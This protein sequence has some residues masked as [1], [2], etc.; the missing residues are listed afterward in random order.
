MPQYQITSPDGSSYEITAPDGASQD[1]VLNYAKQNIQPPKETKQSI[2]DKVLQ[3]L[4]QAAAGTYDTGDTPKAVLGG[5][6]AGLS[7]IGNVESELYAK[8]K[9]YLNG[10]NEAT[11]AYQNSPDFAKTQQIN[12]EQQGLV[13]KINKDTGGTR[14][15]PL[16][17]D[18]GQGD[19]ANFLGQMAPATLA[20]GALGTAAAA[21]TEA[22][23]GSTK[24]IPYIGKVLGNET[25]GKVGGFIGG[26][27]AAGQEAAAQA[28]ANAP[29]VDESINET[30]ANS[31]IAAITAPI[32]GALFAGPKWLMD[33]VK[34]FKNNFTRAGAQ[35][36]VGNDLDNALTPAQKQALQDNAN[37]PSVYD[38]TT[39]EVT[40]NPQAAAMQRDIATKS[41]KNDGTTITPALRLSEQNQANKSKLAQELDAINPPDANTEGLGTAAENHVQGETANINN[42]FKQ[43]E[44][45]APNEVATAPSTTEASANLATN[46]FEAV[47][48]HKFDVDQAHKAIA[49]DTTIQGDTAIAR[50]TFQDIN[51][52]VTNRNVIHGTNDS[53]GD[54]LLARI[55]DR[56]LPT[57]E[58]V[59]EGYHEPTGAN[60]VVPVRQMLDDK[61]DLENY[62]SEKVNQ[63]SQTG[64][65]QDPNINKKIDVAIA[66]KNG[67]MNNVKGLTNTPSALLGKSV[68]EAFTDAQKGTESFYND[69]VKSDSFSSNTDKTGEGYGGSTSKLGKLYYNAKQGSANAPAVE[70]KALFDPTNPDVATDSIKQL[71]NL[72][73]NTSSPEI[74]ANIKTTFLSHINE[75]SGNPAE[76]FDAVYTPDMDTSLRQNGF[77][78]E[79]DDLSSLRDNLHQQQGN[80]DAQNQLMAQAK[81]HAQGQLDR[82]LAS[83]LLDKNGLA[84]P[85]DQQIDKVLSTPKSKAE[86]LNLA[87][88]ENDNGAS[89]RGLGK[90]IIDKL[91]ADNM[92]DSFDI[93]NKPT[94]AIDNV[95]FNK[96][97]IKNGDILQATVPDEYKGLQF[98]NSLSQQLDYVEGASRPGGRTTGTTPSSTEMLKGSAAVEAGEKLG[99]APSSINKLLQSLARSGSNTY[100][101][102]LDEATNPEAALQLISNLKGYKAGPIESTY[103]TLV[104][105]NAGAEA[106]V[107]HLE[108]KS[109][110]PI[111]NQVDGAMTNGGTNAKTG[112]DT[113]SSTI[114]K[115]F[116]NEPQGVVTPAPTHESI[117][118]KVS[119]QTNIPSNFLQG[120][121]KYETQG[122]SNPNTASPGNSSALGRYQMTDKAWQQVQAKHPEANLP[123]ITADNKGTAT[124]PRTDEYNNTL[125]AAYYASDNKNELKDFIHTKFNR[126]VNMGDV[127][128]AHLM[129][130]TGFKQ[131]LSA[132]PN[133]PA[134]TVVPAA[135]KNNKSVFYD[136]QG[137]PL[138]VKQVYAKLEDRFL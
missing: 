86:A 19:V 78:K 38:L 57:Q 30:K 42:T 14:H 67:I 103:N 27:E 131:F 71:G 41:Y 112:F 85:P 59:A 32:A 128:G 40:Q 74:G 106:G 15:I 58:N 11:S 23:L 123:D 24:A 1:D 17:G 47:R 89:V 111:N 133:T 56:Y 63:R 37:N 28:P 22:A 16:I 109:T 55:S 48:Q 122:Q 100:K 121:Q 101:Q 108:K 95:N 29:T 81:D 79:A 34:A 9:D 3:P 6:K 107:E 87:Q 88:G 45:Q 98:V 125:A 138:T 26:T 4:Q 115:P 91:R 96:D 46:S 117:L 68:A 44:L 77:S 134:A 54:P 13:D 114:A 90:N 129:G 7:N 5:A 43:Q 72:A 60:D 124:D 73:N 49:P 102:V 36:S 93:N 118:Q 75:K 135:A 39:A 76:A 105:T 65:S 53:T 126:D 8:G 62:I 35:Q 66:M 110:K 92:Q 83:N 99:I 113:N 104:K 80:V 97:L 116:S 64:T 84:L 94:K 12:T 20:G 70:G 82:T 136:A 51:G 137:K 52:D 130:P 50:N 10:N 61:N 127:H 2:Q 25:V 119:K 120:L 31:K 69:L 132:S 18:V 21:G 33:G